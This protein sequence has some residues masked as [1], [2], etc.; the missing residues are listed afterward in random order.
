MSMNI[1]NR[2]TYMTVEANQKK[3]LIVDL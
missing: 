3:R 1:T 2:K